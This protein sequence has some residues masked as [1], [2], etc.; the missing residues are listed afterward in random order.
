MTTT[1]RAGSSIQKGFLK[2]TIERIVELAEGHTECYVCSVHPM[3]R[4]VN[5]AQSVP[6]NH[7]SLGCRILWQI[8]GQDLY[9]WKLVGIQLLNQQVTRRREYTSFPGLGI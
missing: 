5:T 8:L 6:Q 9:L 1:D 2:R 4:T 7:L 3:G